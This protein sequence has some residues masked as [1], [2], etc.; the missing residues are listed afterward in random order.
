MMRSGQYSLGS[1][2]A[3]TLLGEPVLWW[4]YD[5]HMEPWTQEK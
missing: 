5:D 4:I 3:L 2:K 1:Q